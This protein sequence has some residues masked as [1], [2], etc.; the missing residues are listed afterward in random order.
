MRFRAKWV[1]SHGMDSRKICYSGK[2]VK[3]KQDDNSWQDGWQVKGISDTKKTAT[4]ANDA[5]QLYKKTRKAS[6]I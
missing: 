3:I 5:S 6:D 1:T 4:E 2:Y